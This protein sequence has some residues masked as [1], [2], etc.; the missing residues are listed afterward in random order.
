M[1]GS[2]IQSGGTVYVNG[3]KLIVKGNYRLQ[4]ATTNTDD[5]VSYKYSNG[6]LKMVNE[7]D[8]VTVEG[9]FITHSQH[10]H[11]GL[12]TAGTLEVQGDFTQKYYNNN[13]NFKATGTHIVILS[14]AK[15]RL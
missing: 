10:S 9:D 8:H 6:Y 12:L 11:N 14:G 15:Y 4:T 13:Y 3:G 7:S 2:L 1:N 5:S